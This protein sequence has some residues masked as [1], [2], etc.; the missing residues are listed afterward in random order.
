MNFSQ[1]NSAGAWA[2][3]YHQAA[4]SVIEATLKPYD[5]GST[6]WYV[7]WQLINAGPTPQ[8]D[9]LAYLNIEKTT[10]SGVT[11]ALVRKGLV[12]QAT[13]SNDQRQKILSIT[14]AGQALWQVLPDPIDLILKTAFE[15]IPSDDLAVVVRV[16]STGTERL[17]GLIKKGVER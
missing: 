2:K 1:Q 4:R 16:L 11:S 17:N 7:L 14:P 8:R 3:K 12:E 6:Q 10:L 9:F 13:D 15:G 5:L